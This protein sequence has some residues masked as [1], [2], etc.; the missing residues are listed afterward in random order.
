MQTEYGEIT[1]LFSEKYKKVFEEQQA[2]RRKV[3]DDKRRLLL[4][5]PFDPSSQQQIEEAIRWVFV[6]KIMD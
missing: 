3:E 6:L 4:A 2:M 5:D 1:F